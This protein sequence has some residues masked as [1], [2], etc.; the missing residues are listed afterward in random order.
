[1]IRNALRHADDRPLNVALFLDLLR[2]S[3]RAEQARSRLDSA[4]NWGR[5]GELDGYAAPMS[6]RTRPLRL[7][8][9]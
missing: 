7:T 5:Y 6:E 3:Y 2:R 1:M 4:S 9:A 8:G